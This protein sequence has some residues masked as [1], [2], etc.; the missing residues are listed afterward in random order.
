ME[1]FAKLVVQTGSLD[2]VAGV[3]DQYLDFVCLEQQLFSLAK[4][5]AYVVYNRF[6]ANKQTIE[7]AIRILHMAYSVWLLQLERTPSF[8]VPR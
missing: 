3:H 8:G 2:T 6:G 5:N 1:D 7:S 4:K